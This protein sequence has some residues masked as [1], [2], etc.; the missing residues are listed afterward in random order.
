MSY[1]NVPD[2]RSFNFVPRSL[3]VEAPYRGACPDCPAARME[4]FEPL[5]RGGK[6]LCQFPC[7][8][9]TARSTMPARWPESY[10]FLLVRRG[11]LVRQ[12][13]DARGRASAVDAAGP[14]CLVAFESRED[15][16]AASSGYA[17]TDALVC[18]LPRDAY[19][20]ILSRGGDD[21]RDLIGLHSQA[22]ERL[23][24]L[25][26]ARSHQDAVSAVAAMLL[27][28]ADTL[29]PPRPRD[30][31]PVGLQQRDIAAL[32]G[33]RHETVCRALTHLETSGAVARDP[34]GI[35]IAERAILEAS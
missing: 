28:L 34:D 9:V 12:R 35:R 30:R 29:T 11:V 27:T 24:R 33:I 22:M 21:A 8:A 15:R 32:L 31:I 18:L 14:G 4:V 16:A 20:G 26:H 19:D 5:V 7:V 10:A 23:E 17:A 13:I 2:A 1:A 3:P 25:A 6:G